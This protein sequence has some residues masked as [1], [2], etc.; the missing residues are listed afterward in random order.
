MSSRDSAF[1]A[2]QMET[3]RLD[4]PCPKSEFLSSPMRVVTRRRE[5]RIADAILKAALN[6]AARLGG[7]GIV[8]VGVYVGEDCDI[9]VPALDRALQSV[10]AGTELEKVSID[11]IQQS[12]IYSCSN[13]GSKEASN[14]RREFCSACGSYGIELTGG[15]ELELAFL[16]VKKQ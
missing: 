1:F 3:G 9:Y 7:A 2:A 16:E 15:D 8:R 6:E 12:R 4:V 13:C 11:V 10:C 14:S 5:A